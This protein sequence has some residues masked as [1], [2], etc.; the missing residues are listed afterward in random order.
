MR[1]KRGRGVSNYPR[2]VAMYL[3]QRVGDYKLREISEYFGLNHYGSVGSEMSTMKEQLVK[4]KVCFW[5]I[6]NIIN[7]LDP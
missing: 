6:N 5:D 4:D 2:R 3:A 7:I 1:S